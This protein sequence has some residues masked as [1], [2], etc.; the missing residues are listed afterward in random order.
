M[1]FMDSIALT[2]IAAD[3]AA[4]YKNQLTPLQSHCNQNLV[5]QRLDAKQLD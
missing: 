3:W 1:K 5:T 4:L 2:P